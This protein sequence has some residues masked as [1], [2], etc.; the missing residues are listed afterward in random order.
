MTAKQILDAFSETLMQDE[1]ILSPRERELLTSLLQNSKTVSGNNPQTQSAVAA[2]IAQSVGE[3]VAQRAFALLGGSIVE[4]IL[5]G[6]TIPS[7]GFTTPTVVV[8]PVPQPPGGPGLVPKPPIGPG[9]VP[10]PPS[11]PGWVP[12]PPG[13]PLSP[14]SVPQPPS[15]PKGL[16]P[17]NAPV[18]HGTQP[19]H[20]ESGG[21]VGVLEAPAIVP[22]ECVVLDEFL[23][24]HELDELVS[25]ALQHESE[26]QSSEVI[27]PSGDP[28]VI[29]YEHRRSRVLMDLGKHQEVILERIRCVLP[30]VLD[31]LGI[32][33]FPI[34]NVEAQITASSDGDF[35]RAHSDDAQ[36]AIASR[37]ITFVYFFHREPR[38]FDGGELRLHD[39]ANVP[40]RGFQTIEPQQNQI[41]FFPCSV[42]HEI[43]P[44][45][46]PSTAFA[47]SRFTL[48]GWLHK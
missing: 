2:A 5:A 6:S 37:R 29:D 15:G 30:R 39:S 23:A 31:Q 47:D 27:S 25:Y 26:F 43:T 46:C 18:Q 48:N 33:E 42:L 34:T 12:Q 24:P 45:K 36:E 38:P 3:T 35:F 22:A 13:G 11:G 8:S 19:S 41:V 1:R 14:T 20:L 7:A 21:S 44:V 9:K 17:L 32:E 10:Q 28:G 4:Q 16:Q 40:G